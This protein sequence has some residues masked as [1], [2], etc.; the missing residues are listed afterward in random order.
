MS[1][2]CLCITYLRTSLLEEAIEC[3]LRQTY[4]GPKELIIINDAEDQY[5]EFNHP[6]V[7]IFNTNRRFRTIGEKRNASVAL[8]K[9]DYLAVWDD[10]DIFL[11][12]RLEY[13]FNK[14]QKY[15]L[16]YY[17]L[18]EAFFCENNII[19]KICSNLYFSSSIFSRKLY[20]V[21]EGHG[22]INSGQDAY[23]ESQVWQSYFNKKCN[24]LIEGLN[25]RFPGIR[26]KKISK[27]DIYYMYRWGESYNLS[28]TGKKLNALDIV[29][30]ERRKK[31]KQSGHIKLNPHWKKNYTQICQN[32]I[33]SF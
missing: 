12:H 22:C 15:G 28:L 14:I 23:L 20:S 2:S 8:S 9:Y 33:D 31:E 30:K 5:L 3:F 11:P 17:K 10:D 26:D 29:S 19:K 6:E 24:M 13:C 32:F 16:D 1:I 27:K 21:L 25:H 18:E 4:K 7:F